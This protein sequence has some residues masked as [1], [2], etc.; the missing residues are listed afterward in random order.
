MSL[1]HALNWLLWL[2]AA[3]EICVLLFTRT[4]AGGGMVSDHGS[5]H[6]L[7]PVIGLSISAGTW[8][9]AAHPHTIV[10][11]APWLLVL[12]LS[13]ML[14][15]L[16]VRWTAILSLGKAFSANVAIRDGQTVKSDGLFRFVRHPSYTGMLL[17]LAAI[18]LTTRNW[19][20]LLLVVVPSMAALLYRIHVEE[21]VLE[22][23]FGNAYYEYRVR[24]SRLLPGIY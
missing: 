19:I 1:V 12:A 17:I 18:G 7:W 6:L 5:L 16:V 21:A 2:W 4:R 8:Y 9:G 15:G 11:G 23:A 22:Q 10:H 3:S 14:A 24:T 13:L 20:A